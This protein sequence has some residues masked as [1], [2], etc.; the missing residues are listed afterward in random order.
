MVAPEQNS[1]PTGPVHEYP[2]TIVETHL[3]FFGHVNNATYLQLFEEARWDNITHAG[4]GV[5]VIREKGVGPV[6]LE[7]RLQF[8]KELKNRERITIRTWGKDYKGKV[9]TLIQTMINEKGEEAARAEF[10]F[11]LFDLRA[12]KLL[13]PTPEWKAA[14]GF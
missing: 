10:V 5:D 6:I 12:R 11:G 9:G 13:D 8:K 4:F 1:E 7:V 2:V 14:I 3:D